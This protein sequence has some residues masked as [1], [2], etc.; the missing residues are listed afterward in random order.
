MALYFFMC[1]NLR[2]ACLVNIG[3]FSAKFFQKWNEIWIEWQALKLADEVEELFI[4]HFAEDDKRKAMKYLKPTLRKES[5]SVT[6]FIGE[7]L[8]SN[9]FKCNIEKLVTM[10]QPLYQFTF[11]SGLQRKLH[12]EPSKEQ[13]FTWIL[14]LL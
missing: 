3:E 13:S 10:N 4:K 9:Q 12:T 5:H 2:F 14:N 11:R 1:I 8:S 7:F 6:F